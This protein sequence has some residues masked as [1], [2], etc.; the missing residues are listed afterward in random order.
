MLATPGPRG[1]QVARR[2]RTRRPRRA[3][4]GITY[5]STGVVLMVYAARTRRPGLPDGTGF[6]VPRGMAP[7]TAATWLSSKWP[8]EAFGSRAVVRCYVGAVGEEDVL[9]AD[10]ADIVDACARHLAAV[11][12]LPDAPEHAGRRSVARVDAAVRGGPSRARGPDPTRHCRPV[13]SWWARPTTA[14]ASPIACARP[15]R[16]ASGLP[17]GLTGATSDR[18]EAV[19]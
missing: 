17:L 5:A 2:C 7:M 1:G 8:S 14:S 19:G 6:V 10:D 3:L 18:G 16:R 4:A 12:R 13:S 15:T 11:V 9:D